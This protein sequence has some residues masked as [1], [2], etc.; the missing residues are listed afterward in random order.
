M[1]IV[2]PFL[3]NS[4]LSFVIGLLVAKMLGPDEYGRF[5][6]ARRVAVARRWN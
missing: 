6:L 2:L 3:V 5:A 1:L 4:I